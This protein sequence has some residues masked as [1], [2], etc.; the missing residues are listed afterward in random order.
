MLNLEVLKMAVDAGVTV[1]NSGL[2]KVELKR[3]LGLFSGCTMILGTIIGSGIFVSP[4]GVLQETGS[5]GLALV[6]WGLAGVLV[7][8]GALCY[9][10]LGTL[11]PKSGGA[12][13]YIQEGFGD[14]P[15]FLF[16]WA[17]AFIVLPTGNA[18][19][20]LTFAQYVLQ[21]FYP[22]C[23][24]PQSTILILAALALC[25]YTLIPTPALVVC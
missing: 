18:V 11:I 22:T 17:T 4:R 8:F 2:D 10:E 1:D 13:A 15:A 21:P 7:L 5:V 19:I 24:T 14:M 25:K 20:S 6:V 9:A 23:P 3:T 16:M 12:Y